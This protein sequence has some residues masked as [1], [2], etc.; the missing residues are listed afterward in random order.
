MT[1]VRDV[2]ASVEVFVDCDGVTVISVSA[3]K[4]RADVRQGDRVR[5]ELPA[6]ACVVVRQ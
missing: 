4:D 2:G 3:P 5:V 6:D 1:F